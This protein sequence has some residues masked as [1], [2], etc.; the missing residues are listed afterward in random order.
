MQSTCLL[1]DVEF[2]FLCEVFLIKHGR[3]FPC[4]FLIAAKE[5]LH[6]DIQA[7]HLSLSGVPIT[8]TYSK[9]ICIVLVDVKHTNMITH[10]L[11]KHSPPMATFGYISRSMALWAFAAES[12]NL[13]Y[14]YSIYII[15]ELCFLQCFS[16]WV[17]LCN[18]NS[19]VTIVAEG[20]PRFNALPLDTNAK[21][22]LN[23]RVDA[24]PSF[25]SCP[26]PLAS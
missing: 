25:S 8:D 17:L 22:G 2:C 10:V 7:L 5:T 24:W 1:M 6:T 21:R 9:M 13:K 18:Y 26:K 11:L 15:Y 19:E 16:R 20:M 12:P 14:E 3:I 4:S 23:W